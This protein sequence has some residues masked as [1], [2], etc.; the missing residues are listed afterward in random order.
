MPSWLNI[1]KRKKRIS[2]MLYVSF[3]FLFQVFMRHSRIF[4]IKNQLNLLCFINLCFFSASR[5]LFRSFWIYGWHFTTLAFPLNFIT[6]HASRSLWIDF[7]ILCFVLELSSIVFSIIAKWNTC[8]SLFSW[9]YCSR[10]YPWNRKINSINNMIKYSTFYNLNFK[11]RR[12]VINHNTEFLINLNSKR[13]PLQFYLFRFA[14]L[15]VISIYLYKIFL[16]LD[17]LSSFLFNFCISSTFCNN[18]I[19]NFVGSNTNII[20]WSSFIIIFFDMNFPRNC[21]HQRISSNL[22]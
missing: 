18:F 14:N 16:F 10:I 15:I 9:C 7:D 8:I 11:W 2:S 21:I 22:S 3:N 19:T 20:I 1:N 13:W 6:Q 4:L 5:L 17:I 12:G